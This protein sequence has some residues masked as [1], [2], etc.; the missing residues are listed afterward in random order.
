MLLFQFLNN[1]NHISHFYLLI[2]DLKKL[3]LAEKY[4]ELQKS[5]KLDKYLSKKRKKNAS[6]EK[7]KLPTW[8]HSE[9]RIFKNQW[10]LD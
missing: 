10:S 2:G 1:L 6:K 9:S 3:E 7:K 4:K 5:G 8:K